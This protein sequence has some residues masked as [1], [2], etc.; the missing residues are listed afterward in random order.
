MA[1]KTDKMW[2]VLWEEW[3]AG[4]SDDIGDNSENRK[5]NTTTEKRVVA[6]LNPKCTGARA[7][8]GS[9]Y[10]HMYS[11]YVYVHTGM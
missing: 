7:T 3:G 4:G 5:R 8:T 11:Q 6:R 10:V 9:S 2:M 1:N